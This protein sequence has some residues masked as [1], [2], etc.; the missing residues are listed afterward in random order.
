MLIT[1]GYTDAHWLDQ[2]SIVVH[3]LVANAVMHGGGCLELTLA[4]H[5]SHVTVCAADGSAVVPRRRTA[6]DGGGRGLEMIEALS[7]RWTVENYH[8]GK[9]VCVVLSPYPNAAAE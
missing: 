6:D 8:G 7:Q 1:W 4:A 5:D 2:M 3:E 9:R